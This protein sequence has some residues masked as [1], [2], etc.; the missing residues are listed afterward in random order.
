MSGADSFFVGGALIVASL[1]LSQ[2]WVEWRRG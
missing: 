1:L 2:I